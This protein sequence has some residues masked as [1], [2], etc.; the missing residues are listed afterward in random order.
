MQELARQARNKQRKTEL[1]RWFAQR[2]SLVISELEAEGLRP[3]IQD[4][5]RS[6]EDQ[7]KAYNTGHSK[8]KYGFHNVTGKNGEKE[9]LAVDLLDDNSPLKPSAAYVLKVTAAAE[10]H[11]LTTGARWGLPSKL[12]KAI[13]TAIENEDWKAPVKLGWDPV[14]VEPADFSVEQAAD[15][16][17]PDDA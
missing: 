7:L 17:R 6:V 11:G 4:A 15:G 10:R 5:W 12:A 1:Y 16:Q 9:A 2:L 13:D 8:L 3:R 14:H